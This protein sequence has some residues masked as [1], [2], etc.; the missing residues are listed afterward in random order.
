MKIIP[1]KVSSSKHQ[2]LK[3]GIDL[4]RIISTTYHII[5]IS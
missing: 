5:V 2:W 4:W 3:A 1:D